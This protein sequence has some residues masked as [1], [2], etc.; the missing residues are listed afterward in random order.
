MHITTTTRSRSE[1]LSDNVSLQPIISSSDNG[2]KPDQLQ[3]LTDRY[4]REE[5]LLREG[6]ALH[7]DKDDEIARRRITQKYEFLQTDLAVPGA[8][9]AGVLEHWFEQNKLR[10][11]M[12]ERV[13]FSHVYVSADKEG[14]AV[15]KVHAVKILMELHGMNA[16]RAPALGDPFPGPSDVGNLAPDEAERLFGKSELSGQLFK[17]PL[18][19][20][21]GP[22]RSGCGWHL[23]YVTDHLLPVLPSSASIRERVLADYQDEQRR[24]LNA[25][26]FEKLRTQ[27]T[28]RY[29]E[30]RR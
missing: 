3:G 23:V 29:D 18:R 11:L 17:P 6:L 16:A 30:E 2:P 1:R 28:I 14:D 20:W 21:S 7:L 19:T 12:P 13:A 10:Y 26:N 22:Y 15:A 24:I 5:I 8:L 27:Y 4:I 9:D 25:R